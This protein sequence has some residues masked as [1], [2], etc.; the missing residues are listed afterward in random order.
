MPTEIDRHWVRR[1]L[2]AGG[3]LVGVLP[4]EEYAAENIA[5]PIASRSRS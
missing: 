5:G 1:L 3:Q 2:A 4:A